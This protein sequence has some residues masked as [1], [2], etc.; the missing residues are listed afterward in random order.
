MS[1]GV[2]STSHSEDLA[3]SRALHGDELKTG[4]L[5]K[6]ASKNKNV[7]NAATGDYLSLWKKPENETEEDEKKRLDSYTQLTNTYY[8]LATDF[9][10]YGWGTSFHFS[11]FYP[12]EEFNKAIA[13]HEHY[14]AFKMNIKSNYRVLDVGCGV[15]GPA[16]E[17]AHFTGAH[18]TG[19]NN[20]D[21]QIARAFHYA[22]K[23]GLEHQ[24]NFIKGN[25]MEMPFEEAQY[26]AVYA[27]E[28]TVHAPKFEG[29]YGEIFRVLKPGGAFGCYEWCMTDDYD[30]TN[31]DH[32]RIAHG[33]EIGNGIPKMRRIAECLQALRNVGFEIEIH[34]DLANV[35]DSVQWYYPL[36]GEFKKCQ[37]ARDYLTTIAMTP[38]G[39]FTT[40]QMVR[41]L[42]KVGLAPK[43]SYDTQKFLETAADALVEGARANLFTP[44]FFF[45]ARKPE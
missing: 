41:V 25:F 39:R 3:F 4:F 8:N 32:H 29:V 23:E 33:I 13:R 35:G 28:A 6:M 17:I 20:N 2:V 38:V 27:I 36:E 26:D 9:Y 43:G 24:T 5:S 10:E 18:I 34:Q 19:L 21:Y 30:E 1:N 11:R 44:M 40:T 12:G 42:E 22:K 31:A 7:H 45:V 15:G 37:S 16:R 14:L